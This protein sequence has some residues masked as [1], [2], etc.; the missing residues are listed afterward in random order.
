MYEITR[1]G[2]FDSYKQHYN[3]TEDTLDRWKVPHSM[4]KHFRREELNYISLMIHDTLPENYCEKLLPNDGPAEGKVFKFFS[5]QDDIN[6]ARQKWYAAIKKEYKSFWKTVISEIPIE[7]LDSST[8]VL[9]N[10]I[11]PIIKFINPQ[12][13]HMIYNHVNYMVRLNKI[14]N[15]AT[16]VEPFVQCRHKFYYEWMYLG[17]NM[18]PPHYPLYKHW[19]DKNYSNISNWVHK[20]LLYKDF[21]NLDLYTTTNINL[22]VTKI[23]L[24]RYYI[25]NDNDSSIFRHL[26]CSFEYLPRFF[27]NNWLH[28]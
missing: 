27:R 6:T 12:A 8:L 5:M 11:L 10:D 25:A 16:E 14:I 19:N 9:F 26:F 17:W 3:K 20:R 22:L 18:L 28:I 2:M 15:K 13:I 24:E 4:R 7:S 21:I 1:L 23:E